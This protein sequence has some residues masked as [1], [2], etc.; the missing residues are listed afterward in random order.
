[1]LHIV[2]TMFRLTFKFWRLA[3][4]NVR[5]A[6]LVFSFPWGFASQAMG[7]VE[8]APDPANAD[9]EEGKHLAD[10]DH[11]KMVHALKVLRESVMAGETD[12]NAAMTAH[13]LE[14]YLVKHSFVSLPV[15]VPDEGDAPIK[16]FQFLHSQGRMIVIPT[17]NSAALNSKLWIVQPFSLMPTVFAASGLIKCDAFPFEDTCTMDIIEIISRDLPDRGEIK[18]WETRESDVEGCLELF[19]PCPPVPRS[20]LNSKTSP[21]LALVDALDHQEFLALNRTVEHSPRSGLFY[22]GR[23]ITSRQSY[24]QCVLASKAIFGKGQRCFKPGKSES[25]LRFCYG[26]RSQSTLLLLRET[27]N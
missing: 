2:V 22:D 15:T 14:D 27:A 24:L 25:F 7:S 18:V 16:V 17:H 5:V 10:A 4:V 6:D 19:N 8:D 3:H 26:V 11:S 13:W 1:M 9:F 20:A 12:P 23:T 21:I